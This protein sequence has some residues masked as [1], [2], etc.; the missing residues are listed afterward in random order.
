MDTLLSMR[1]FN[2]V[3]TQG[4]FVGAA[5][6]LGLSTA[7]VSK[8][9]K[10]LEQ[11]LGSR[12]LNRTTR[13]L[14]LTGPGEVYFERCQQVLSELDELETNLRQTTVKPRGTL[15]ISAPVTFCVNYL[16]PVMVDYYER[17]PDMKV[18]LHLTDRVVDLVEDGFDMGIRIS[19]EPNPSL[20]ARRLSPIK[21]RLVASPAYLA[22]HG[23]PQTPQDLTNHP[24]ITYTYSNHGTA[25][26]FDGP[27]G[28]VTVNVHP[29][30]RVNNADMAT[31]AALDGLGL[32]LQPTILTQ[33]HLRSGDLV[34]LLCDYPRPD[35]WLYA[36]YPNRTHLTAKVR[37]FIDLLVEHFGEN[38]PWN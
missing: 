21:L 22:K 19:A 31:R 2:Q 14:S 10:H 26:Q 9:V 32:T 33:Q 20:V 3:A 30:L 7:M 1:V 28:K 29:R 15:K 35:I 27:E 36:V 5:T 12:L 8:H 18:D 34:P 24:C 16:G 25:W 11:H 6:R 13:H 38:P 37:T 17:Y 23:T 4:S